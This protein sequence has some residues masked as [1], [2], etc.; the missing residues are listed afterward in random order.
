MLKATA[1]DKPL[2]DLAIFCD[3]M[4]PEQTETGNY[5]ELIGN[6]TINGIKTFLDA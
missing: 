3:T 6:Q 5:V 2:N 1:Y 4:F